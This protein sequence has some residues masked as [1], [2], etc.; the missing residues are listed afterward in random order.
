MARGRL[1]SKSLGSSRRFH[2]LL[3][4]GGKLGEFCQVLFPLI[5]A[6]TDDFGRMP[7]DAFTVK[8][9]VM[10]SSRRTEK[11]FDGALDVIAAVG[12]VDRYVVEG[13]IYLQVNQFD[14]HQPNLHKRTQSRFPEFPGSS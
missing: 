7:G 4:H 5:I 13:A 3:S 12:L 6:N 8:N 11:D 1:I 9:V 2:S 10:P 14:E